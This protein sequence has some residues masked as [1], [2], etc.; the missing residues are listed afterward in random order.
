M[1]TKRLAIALS[2][3]I[4]AA[5]MCLSA[6][7]SGGMKS[8]DGSVQKPMMKDSGKQMNNTMDKHDDVGGSM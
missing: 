4:V 5:G 1:S 7:A 3:I 8:M 6:C 2:S